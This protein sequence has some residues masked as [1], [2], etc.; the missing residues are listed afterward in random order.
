MDTVWKLKI[1]F[2]LVMGCL[3]FMASPIF[4]EETW[5]VISHLEHS[6]VR[7]SD[8][9]FADEN[10]GWAIDR[11]YGVLHT[12][13]GGKTWQRKSPIGDHNYGVHFIDK[14]HG[15]IVGIGVILRTTDG[16]RTWKEVPVPGWF[17][18]VHFV[19]EKEG[20]VVG[21]S[22]DVLLAPN[23][24]K[25]LL[26]HTE[27]GGQSWKVAY[28]GKNQGAFY[29]VHFPSPQKGWVVGSTILH[30]SDGGQ[31]WVRQGNGNGGYSVYFVDEK[32]GWIAWGSRIL[33]TKNGGKN[34]KVVKI[35]REQVPNRSLQDVQFVNKQ[36]GWIVGSYHP[37]VG[38]KR[39][40][41]SGIILHT[42]DGG[43]NW[44]ILETDVP[45]Y[46][47]DF[48]AENKGWIAGDDNIILHTDDGEKWTRQTE[49]A[50]YYEDV[51]FL[52]PKDGWI[53]GSSVTPIGWSNILHTT[54]SGQTWTEL[55]K[56]EG[57]LSAIHFLNKWEGWA[58][59][60][61]LFHTLDGGKNW[62]ARSERLNLID[63]YFANSEQG[64]AIG[65]DFVNI[66][67]DGG[68]TWARHAMKVKDL[69]EP[70]IRDVSFLNANEGWAVSGR[71]ILYT[72]DGG[73]NW[74]IQK[75]AQRR[76][77]AIHFVNAKHGWAVGYSGAILHTNDSG[78]R[79][80]IQDSGVLANLIDVLFLSEEEGWAVGTGGL[81][82]RTKNS[83]K[84]W[85]L[86]QTSANVTLMRIA[87]TR[88]TDLIAVGYW[89]AILAYHDEKLKEYA[90]AFDVST[91]EKHIATWG[92]LKS[93]LH[94][95]FPNPFNPDTWIP[96][97]LSQPAH[98]TFKIYDLKGE[99]VKTIPLGYRQAG[100]Y[101]LKE[102]AAHWDGRNSQGEPVSSGIYFY[103]I[104]T[105]DFVASK[106]MVLTR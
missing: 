94:R 92:K 99:V 45:L 49:R 70:K 28:K 22:D 3:S 67:T 78:K 79:W 75:R 77:L 93:R 23:N 87:Y 46:A 2:I 88:G 91:S 32:E 52:S 15:W 17:M 80:K 6:G 31:T 10:H 97:E 54:D 55:S 68:K 42:K 89:N 43:V 25:A 66:T 69:P 36:E 44:E 63:I 86:E 39:R 56:L 101:L 19:S 13:N 47:L 29:G 33:H 9:S 26:L 100:S 95:N 8:I 21:M 27:D 90:K 50:Y 96:Y 103:T 18:D 105:G 12:Q 98:V 73:I 84:T 71:E 16:G 81:V 38:G 51:Y 14:N 41:V 40:V 7:F 53:V 5:Q 102:R 11:Y 74:K 62:E 64:L 82:L 30:T 60:T 59:G 104:I 34:W 57:R 37:P 4:A 85:K 61:Y 35:D 24:Q 83:G 76:L 48:P 58:A 72:E 1:V 65:K 106:K 20:W